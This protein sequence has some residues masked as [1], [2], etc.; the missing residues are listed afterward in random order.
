MR[1]DTP[2]SVSVSTGIPGFFPADDTTVTGTVRYGAVGSNQIYPLQVKQYKL[3]TSL[4][5]ASSTA[6]VYRVDVR[7]MPA[8][9][10]L[11]GK[12]GIPG[13]PT[14]PRYGEFPLYEWS[15]KGLV[16]ILATGGYILAP[17]IERPS[18]ESAAVA[19]GRKLLVDHGLLPPDSREQVEVARQPFGVSITFHR[20]LGGL[21]VC[22]S[23]TTLFFPQQ[24]D[25]VVMATHRP[26]AGGSK[27]P[28]RSAAAGWAQAAAAQKRPSDR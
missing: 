11:A 28:L 15:E 3:A 12:R 9:D 17:A 27:Y 19:S 23:G 4:Q 1:F 5:M 7:S 8:P 24:G 14:E 16:Y 22:G 21:T 6:P 20:R 25:A 2:P 10:K 18:D 26:L 13:S